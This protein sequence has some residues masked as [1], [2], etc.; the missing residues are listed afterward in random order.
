MFVEHSISDLR[1]AQVLIRKGPK[2]QSTLK[3]RIER[4][5]NR[6]RSRGESYYINQMPPGWTLHLHRPLP[7]E[8][9][10]TEYQQMIYRQRQRLIKL[11]KMEQEFIDNFKQAA[12]GKA[13]P[14]SKKT[15]MST[16]KAKMSIDDSIENNRNE[17]NDKSKDDSKANEDSNKN[18]DDNDKYY[19]P[20]SQMHIVD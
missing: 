10:D 15:R 8:E 12:S 16:T 13:T 3:Q 6:R 19:D 14:T 2:G 18:D 11:K 4:R 9:W 5:K 1:K 17:A 7:P 20:L